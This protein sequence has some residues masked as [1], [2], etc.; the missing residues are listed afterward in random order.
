MGHIDLLKVTINPAE[1]CLSW[2]K[3]MLLRKN[4][5]FQLSSWS[6][7]YPCY[8]LSRAQAHV[9]TFKPTYIDHRL[10][11]KMDVVRRDVAHVLELVWSSEL[12]PALL[13]PSYLR[14]NQLL[15]E[16]LGCEVILSKWP[17]HITATFNF[18]MWHVLT[19]NV[20]FSDTITAKGAAFDQQIHFSEHHKQSEFPFFFL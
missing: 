10:C 7:Q 9:S 1:I 12:Q 13:G 4:K 19:Q 16:T 6:I 15:G 2:E 14:L 17:N 18:I 20:F 3:L 5:S 11:I 8:S